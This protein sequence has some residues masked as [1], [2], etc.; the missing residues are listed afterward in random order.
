M[1]YNMDD[2]TNPKY[3]ELMSLA[4]RVY[5]YAA[6]KWIE[7]AG[8]QK[9]VSW[10]LASVDEIAALADSLEMFI[11]EHWTELHPEEKNLNQARLVDEVIQA[12][13]DRIVDLAGSM[14]KKEEQLILTIWSQSHF[15]NSVD[16]DQPES[17]WFKDDAINQIAV[18]E[19]ELKRLYADLDQVIAKTEER[20]N[21]E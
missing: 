21:K 19:A 1:N 17:E 9:S 5:E 3:L 13:A 12:A 18:A 15:V 7:F 16:P 8:H 2:M 10:E 20:L 11:T 4:R 6:H 14:K